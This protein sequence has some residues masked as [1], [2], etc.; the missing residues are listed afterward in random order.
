MV[1]GALAIAVGSGFVGGERKPGDDDEA[2][3]A[4]VD[5]RVVAQWP[6]P[7]GEAARRDTVTGPHGATVLE[8][9]ST[10]VRVVEWSCPHG[11][12]R[13]DGRVTRAGGMIVCAPNRLVVTL[14]GASAPTAV[15]AI[16]H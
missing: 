10:A 12:C 4:T 7:E 9:T 6:F 5:G 8:T 14:S 3:H 11:W 2:I 15:D 16:T 13:R 1:A